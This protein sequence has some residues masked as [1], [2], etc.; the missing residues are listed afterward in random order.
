MDIPELS[1]QVQQAILII[2]I[3][4]ATWI[5]VRFFGSIIKKAKERSAVFEIDKR[6]FKAIDRM[7]DTIAVVMALA[8]SLNFLGISGVLYTTLT[9]F[10]VIALIIGM[11]I[12]DLASNVFA[13]I[14][15]IFSP[16]FLI[17]EYI[18][19]DKYEGTV[20]KLSLRMTILR[21]SDGVLI[22][23]PNT[24]LITE[25]IINFSTAEKRRVEIR[26]G[27]AN[28]NDI[29]MALQQ[30][31]LAA[32]EHDKTIKSEEIEVVMTDVK[33]YAVDLTMRFWVHPDDLRPST[34]EI[35]KSITARFK[36]NHIELAVPL[37]KYV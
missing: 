24:L 27:I 32:V 13:G 37:R 8:L 16:S 1:E 19:V 33:D 28:E 18:A 31:R 36:E 3:W 12:K 9:A 7:F 29:E 14:M 25:P 6:T 2:G 21:R 10:G 11:A 20:E 22:N 5:F 26:V 15:M 17:G 23:I 4:I 34:S 35:L 30:L